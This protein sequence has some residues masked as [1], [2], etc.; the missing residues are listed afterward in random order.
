[1]QGS[2]GAGGGS[3]NG[4]EQVTGEDLARISRGSTENR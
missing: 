4:A 3:G 1:M 2:G